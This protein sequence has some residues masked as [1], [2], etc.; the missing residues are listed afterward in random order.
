[1]RKLLGGSAALALLVS[2]SS[3]GGEHTSA[4]AAFFAQVAA[5]PGGVISV[6]DLALDVRGATLQLLDEGLRE[7][8]A[9]EAQLAN[10]LRPGMVVALFGEVHGTTVRV[11]DVVHRAAVRGTLAGHGGYSLQ[12]AGLSAVLA[13]GTAV[14]DRDGAPVDPLGLAAGT[15]VEVNGWGEA[16]GPW[17]Q[18]TGVRVLAAAPPTLARGWSLGTPEQGRL[19]VALAP[20]GA[21]ALEVDLR[22]LAPPP[23][24][25]AQALLRCQGAVQEP[26]TLVATE[27]AVE[28]VLAPIDSGVAVIEGVVTRV[29]GGALELGPYRVIVPPEAVFAGVPAGGTASDA[30]APGARLQVRAR[31]DGAGITAERIRFLGAERRTGRTVPGSFVLGNGGTGA[32]DLG[33]DT[34]ALGP[35]TIIT[36]PDGARLTVRDLGDLHG[37]APGGLPLTVHGYTAL[38]GGLRA[39]RV[40]VLGG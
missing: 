16:A 19:S 7:T 1:M 21:R 3:G 25:P 26:D 29:D 32:V 38:D 14:V 23:T 30:L 31:V 2:C 24:V 22:D 5:G 8:V 35:F 12:L 34:V 17:V 40:E 6:E 36:D 39:Y 10:R 37:Q 4:P 27:V 11:S 33:L 28:S 9:D 15:P 18:V 13:P 20:G